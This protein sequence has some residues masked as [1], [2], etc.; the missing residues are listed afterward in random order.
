MRRHYPHKPTTAVARLIGHSVPSTYNR[1]QKLGLTKSPEYFAS[2]AA[3]RMA[4]GDGRGAAN[5]FRPGHVPA[6]KGLR[7]PGWGPGRMKST[8]FKLGCRQGVAAN[9]WRP[10]GTILTDTDGYSRIKVRE[11]T[12]GEAYGFGNVRVW[13]LLQRHVWAEAHGPIPS[14]HAVAFKNG[15]K[16][17][18]RLENLELLSRADLMKR[19]TVHNLPKPLAQAVQL[20]GA[21][22][23]QIRKREG[24]V[25]QKQNRRSA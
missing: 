7:R 12:K 22:T 13:P 6:N 20:I 15:D 10:I 2:A 17:D 4:K 8:Q 24:H 19:N 16:R 14:G 9:N 1:A 3:G 18:C 5:R 11:A 21:I 23:R 25:D